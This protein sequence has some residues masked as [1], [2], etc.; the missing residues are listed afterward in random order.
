MILQRGRL[1]LTSYQFEA[2]IMNE[3]IKSLGEDLAEK[4]KREK[5][6]TTEL[7]IANPK[8][9]KDSALFP[10]VL[11]TLRKSVPLFFVSQQRDYTSSYLNALSFP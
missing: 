6:P 3:L 10:R 7:D 5:L 11:W 9:K 1:Y 2:R 8:P 4:V